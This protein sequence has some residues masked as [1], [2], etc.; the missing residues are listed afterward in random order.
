MQSNE[1]RIAVLVAALG[2][3]VVLFV[4]LSGDDDEGSSTATT[5]PEATK[6]NQPDNGQGGPGASGKQQGQAKQSRGEE[7]PRITIKGGKPVGGIAKLSA[8]S[9]DQVRFVVVSDTEGEVHV[10]GYEIFEDV[11]PGKPTEVSF[12][13][14]IEGAFEIELHS[15]T[16]G[17][18]EIG[19]LEVNP[20]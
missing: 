10:H 6:A 12:P 16:A 14:E 1:A 7:L 17:E 13:A 18:F 2:A 15:H 20:D 19:E 8:V 5:T 3:A 4:V 11:A 9:G